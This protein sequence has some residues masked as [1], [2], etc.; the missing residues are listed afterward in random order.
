MCAL[1][2][3]ALVLSHSLAS[4]SATRHSHLP[5]HQSCIQPFVAASTAQVPPI[6]CVHDF[7]GALWAFNQLVPKLPGPCLGLGC[8][9]ALLRGCSSFSDLASRYALALPRALWPAQAPIPLLGYSLGCR[10]AH[11]MTSQL[12]A[13]GRRVVLILLD[14]PIG[15]ASLGHSAAL[16][17]LATSVGAPPNGRL[18][19]EAGV[20]VEAVPDLLLRALDAAGAAS[21]EVAS[22]LM[23]LTDTDPVANHPASGAA[24]DPADT[25][26]LYVAARSSDHRRQGTLQAA[27]ECRPQSEIREVDGSHFDFLSKSAEEVARL[28]ADFMARAGR[29]RGASSAE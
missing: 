16:Q 1:T 19:A 9:P 10:I 5:R 8:T 28:V 29:D 24:T 12:E 20:E 25:P 27:L 14:G 23:Q 21:R 7:T 4:P 2:T 6:V 18:Q 22:Q 17:R 3:A 15:A 11:R 13:E 26:T